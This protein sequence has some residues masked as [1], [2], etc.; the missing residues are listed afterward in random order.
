M[1]KKIDILIS[2]ILQSHNLKEI[3]KRALKKKGECERVNY[4][5]MLDGVIDT[6]TYHIEKDCFTISLTMADNRN[7][8]WYR[9]DTYKI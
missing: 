5:I 8:C 1:N 2:R 6:I 4:P 7:L 9:I 3:K